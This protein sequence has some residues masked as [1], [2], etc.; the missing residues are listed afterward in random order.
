MDILREYFEK[1]FKTVY[2]FQHWSGPNLTGKLLWTI[3]EHNIVMN[4]G[5]NNLIDTC[6]LGTAPETDFYFELAGGSSTFAAAD[7][8]SS[9]AGWTENQDYD[10]ATRQVWTGVRSGQNVTNSASP[11]VI[12]VTTGSTFGGA[13]LVS[14]NI[15]GNNAAGV[16]FSGVNAS[17]GD[18]VLGAGG[19]LSMVYSITGADDGV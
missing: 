8:P 1:H 12:T 19:S 5:L 7:T 10:E 6:L 18:Q 2:K 17:Q 15:K 4:G 16:M 13:A 9:H 11:A 14:S 3:E